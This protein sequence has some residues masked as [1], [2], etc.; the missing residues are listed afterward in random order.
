MFIMSHFLD[1]GGQ[2]FWPSGRG[3]NNFLS[4]SKRGEGKIGNTYHTL[5]LGYPKF[6]CY[7]PKFPQFVQRSMMF[8]EGFHVDIDHSQSDSMNS[9]LN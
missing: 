6:H 8:S 5:A 7:L 2:P 9:S 1:L 3:G 4:N